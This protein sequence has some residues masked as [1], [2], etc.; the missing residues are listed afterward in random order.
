MRVDDLIAAISS[1]RLSDLEAWIR[2]RLVVLQHEASLRLA[3]GNS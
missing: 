3:S 2:E 1:L